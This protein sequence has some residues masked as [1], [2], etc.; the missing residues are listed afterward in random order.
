MSE[1]GDLVRVRVPNPLFRDWLTKHYA[2]LINEALSELDRPMVQIE[3]VA[4]TPSGALPAAA[5]AAPPIAPEEAEQA[6][7]PAANGGASDAIAAPAP[8]AAWGG[9]PLDAT[10]GVGLNLRYT[11]DTFVVGP[12]NQFAEAASRAVAEA[13]ARS[14]NPLFIYGGVGLGKTHLMHAIGHYVLQQQPALQA[15][16]HLDRAVHERDDQR[17]EDTTA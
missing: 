1:S 8:G 17:G 3:F 4:D 10:P 16:L 11:F 12:S 15:D 5:E 9:L 6:E 14:Y 13:P 2:G 7:A